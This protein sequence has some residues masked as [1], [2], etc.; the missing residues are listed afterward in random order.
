MTTPDTKQ[1]LREHLAKLQ[2]EEKILKAPLEV[3][4]AERDSFMQAN[5]LVFETD[6][7][8]AKKIKLAQADPA[9]DAIEKEIS[10]TAQALGGLRMSDS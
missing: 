2:A 9:I 3:L 6:R 4:R 10:A 8:L 1:L 7:A 5:A